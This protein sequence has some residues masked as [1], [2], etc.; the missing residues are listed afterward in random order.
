[1]N[2]SDGMVLPNKSRS[3]LLLMVFIGSAV[4]SFCLYFLL[5]SRQNPHASAYY[6]AMLYLVVLPLL[7]LYWRASRSKT[8]IECYFRPW[9]LVAVAVFA[10]VALVVGKTTEYGEMVADESSYMFQAR[11]FAAGKL[12]AESMAF[13]IPNYSSVRAE[14]VFPEI[15]FEDT[16]QSNSGWFSKYT[17]GWPLILAAGYLIRLPW[18]VNPIFGLLQLVLVWRLAQPWGAATQT[19]SILFIT[20]S[21][22]MLISSVGFLSHAATAFICLSALWSLLEGLREKRHGWI[23]LSFLLVMGV[24]LLRPYTGGLLG[25]MCAGI[26]IWELRSRPRTM[27]KFLII[28]GFAGAFAAAGFFFCNW[29]FTGDVRLSPYALW[30]GQR[31]IPDLTFNVSVVAHNA[32]TVW[33]WAITDTVRVTF[34]FLFLFVAFACWKDRERR[35][36]LIYLALFFPVLI[37]AHM[38][39]SW[40][41]GS[42]SFDGER[43]YFEG[44]C[45]IAIVAARGFELFVSTWRVRP[46]S[47]FAGLAVLLGLQFAFLILTV[48]DIETVLRPYR[49]AHEVAISPPPVPLKFLSGNFP[50]FFQAKTVNWNEANWRNAG[51]LYLIDPGPARREQVACRFGRYFYRVVE[52]DARTKKFVKSDAAAKCSNIAFTPASASSSGQE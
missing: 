44:F 14:K 10:I 28:A 9:H 17:P 16:I 43:Y 25:L 32:A 11:V 45:A 20:T 18:L 2:P 41:E 34:P 29:L 5:D 21:G 27:M 38:L 23:I 24:T 48:K 6:L 46:A 40:P 22:Y 13:G 4:L 51:T 42:G 15:Y 52:Y 31:G 7:L 1:M 19:L 50:R 26:A 35:A 30:K 8:A 37:A 12:K 47:V 39:A 33:R 3:A 49:E 36:H